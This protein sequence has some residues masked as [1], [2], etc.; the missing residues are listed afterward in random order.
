M[1]F[2]VDLTHMVFQYDLQ[3]KLICVSEI[4]VSV[5]YEFVV[6]SFWETWQT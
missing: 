2:Y 3:Q 6:I 5:C 4:Q 1:S